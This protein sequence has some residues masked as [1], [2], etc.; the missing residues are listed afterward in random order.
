VVVFHNRWFIGTVDFR[1]RKKVPFHIS[2]MHG[3]TLPALWGV[4]LPNIHESSPGEQAGM[5]KEIEWGVSGR[6]LA[7]ARRRFCARPS[8][9]GE[10]RRATARQATGW[11]KGFG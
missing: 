1:F 3:E 5:I 10:R 11:H 7:V 6:P 2:I 4:T 9:W 8:G